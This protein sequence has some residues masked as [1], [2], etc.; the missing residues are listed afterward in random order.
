MSYLRPSPPD[1]AP[2]QAARER[3][4]LFARCCAGVAEGLEFAALSPVTGEPVEEVRGQAL[5]ALRALLPRE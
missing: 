2:Q 1:A 5:L 3:C 4:G